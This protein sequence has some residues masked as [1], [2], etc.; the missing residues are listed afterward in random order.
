[1]FKQLVCHNYWGRNYS[2][3][4]YMGHNCLGTEWHVDATAEALEDRIE[5]GQG[6]EGARAVVRALARHVP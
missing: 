4:N 1:M 5:V 2:G 6:G 3:R